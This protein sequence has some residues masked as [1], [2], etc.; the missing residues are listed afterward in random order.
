MRK[1][2]LF[3]CKLRGHNWARSRVMPGIKTCRR[4]SLQ[5][6]VNKRKA[7]STEAANG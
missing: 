7:K 4:C 5:R 6:A 1:W 3:I 2:L